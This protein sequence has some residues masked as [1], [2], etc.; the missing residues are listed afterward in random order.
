MK[1]LKDGSPSIQAQADLVSLDPD[2]F[3]LVWTT[4]D[5]VATEI[6]YLVLGAGVKRRRVMVVH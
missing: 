3:T 5:A 6:L 2:G 4:N 1:Y